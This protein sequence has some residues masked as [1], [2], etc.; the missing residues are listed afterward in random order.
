MNT[1]YIAPFNALRNRKARLTAVLLITIGVT[2]SAVVSLQLLHKS[3]E[4]ERLKLETLTSSSCAN[5]ARSVTSYILLFL[6]N[7][8]L[9]LPKGETTEDVLPIICRQSMGVNVSHK[10][11]AFRCPGD[12]SGN[13]TPYCY[14]GQGLMSATVKNKSA[15]VFFCPATCHAGRF[16]HSHAMIGDELV[17]VT[18]KRDMAQMLQHAIQQAVSCDVPYSDSAIYILRKELALCRLP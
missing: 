2:L 16:Y 12:S 3:R 15:L 6:K 18:D 10:L 8:S 7:T 11:Q 5:H 17:C 1:D 4:E 9:L 13:D 14:V